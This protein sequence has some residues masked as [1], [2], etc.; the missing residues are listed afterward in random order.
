MNDHQLTLTSLH[1]IRIG[2]VYSAYGTFFGLLGFGRLQCNVCIQIE[3][4]EY[5][6]V[7]SGTTVS[8]YF[9]MII[10]RL[11]IRFVFLQYK[12]SEVIPIKCDFH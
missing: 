4:V 6:V 5:R 8:E 1:N 3:H 10:G 12:L 11:N 2:G 7:E 9:E